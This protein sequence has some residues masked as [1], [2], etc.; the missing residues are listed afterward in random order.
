[1]CIR[2]SDKSA[3]SIGSVEVIDEA[4]YWGVARGD[5]TDIGQ[6]YVVENGRI[7]GEP[8]AT[9]SQKLTVKNPNGGTAKLKFSIKDTAPLAGKTIVAMR[10]VTDAAGNVVVEHRDPAD[11][12]QQ[13][14]FPKI[15]TDATGDVDDEANAGNDTVTITDAV[16]YENLVPGKEYTLSASLH[17]RSMKDGKPVDGGIV[18]DKAGKDVTSSVTF[19]PDTANGSVDVV[20]TFTTVDDLSL[21]HI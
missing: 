18:K 12:M 10:T 5:Y 11:P 9:A 21:I 15:G 2:D 14:H 19:T 17:Y 3:P 8:V 16:S 20:F 4:D 6:L 1:M 7:V 13:L